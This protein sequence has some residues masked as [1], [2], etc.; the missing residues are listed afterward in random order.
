MYTHHKLLSPLKF[1]RTCQDV[2]SGSTFS[3]ILKYR[4]EVVDNIEDKKSLGKWRVKALLS[5][6]CSNTHRHYSFSRYF[7]ETRTRLLQAIHDRLRG[8][9]TPLPNAYILAC[10]DYAELDTAYS[11]DATKPTKNM[12]RFAELLK[13]TPNDYVGHSN[14]V[15]RDVREKMK[16]FV[17]TIRSSAMWQN[18]SQEVRDATDFVCG[19]PDNPQDA[20]QK[21][22]KKRKH[23]KSKAAT[24]NADGSSS[25]SP[26]TPTATDI[27]DIH[28]NTGSFQQLLANNRLLKSLC[29]PMSGVLI[30]H[31]PVPF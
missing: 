3:D 4:S 22:K 12:R 15:D 9:A 2:D 11:Y 29:E 18:Y 21:S 26:S 7:R 5:W 16:A 13:L 23:G 24:A 17:H 8:N 30:T 14:N 1:I 25:T 28:F 31:E 20:T 19:T 6:F 27:S 10:M